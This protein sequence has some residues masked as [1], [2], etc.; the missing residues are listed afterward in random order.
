MLAWEEH[1]EP[2]LS[3]ADPK[4]G[5]AGT[6]QLLKH[7]AELLFANAIWLEIWRVL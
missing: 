7:F 3:H 2:R 1:N 6:L 4:S 5:D